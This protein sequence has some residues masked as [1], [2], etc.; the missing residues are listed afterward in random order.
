M[1]FRINQSA[2]GYGCDR[3]QRQHDQAAAIPTVVKEAPIP[4][5]RFMT[6]YFGFDEFLFA[7]LLKPFDRPGPGDHGNGAIHRKR[8]AVV[9]SLSK[10]I[11]VL[12]AQSHGVSGRGSLPA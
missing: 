7:V 11:P 6:T 1:I 8:K 3:H 10:P 2:S 12:F 9:E 5:Q 4:C